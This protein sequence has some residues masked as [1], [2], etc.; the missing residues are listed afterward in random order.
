MKNTTKKLLASS[1][2]L[3]LAAATSVGSAYAWFTV[4][5]KVD[6]A[7]INMTVKTGNNLYVALN[8]GDWDRTIDLA[9]VFAKPTDRAG[10]IWDAVTTGD[11]K[12]FYTLGSTPYKEEIIN[13]LDDPW[14]VTAKQ[15]KDVF[16]YTK[17]STTANATGQVL[18]FAGAVNTDVVVAQYVEFTLHFALAGASTV[19][20]SLAAATNSNG[21][22]HQAAQVL[23][24]ADSTNGKVYQFNTTGGSVDTTITSDY[25]LS[26]FNT[27]YNKQITTGTNSSA[28][29]KEVGLNA[30]TGLNAA[31]I[32]D[33]F[34]EVPA[35]T[36][37]TTT[38]SST[39]A[40]AGTRTALVGDYLY[41]TIKFSVWYEGNDYSCANEIFNQNVQANLT[42]SASI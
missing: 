12:E 32:K 41:G 37:F 25:A 2:T 5:A 6:V 33:K 8:G 1:I 28:T 22:T 36:A 23:R 38:L 27:V 10:I 35:F 34:E 20:V 4:N 14:D 30:I 21:A 7:G 17:I 40:P 13:P 16:N 19:N 3:G 26:R 18:S 9:S 29:D 39:S 31:A 42:F 24:I 11:G 15:V